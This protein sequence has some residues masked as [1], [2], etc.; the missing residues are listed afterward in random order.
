VIKIPIN[1]KEQIVTSLKVNPEL[2][3]HAKIAALEGDI[4]LG[5]LIDRAI[6]EY[7]EKQ[8]KCKK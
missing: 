5:E 8:E 3:K 1:E 4:T 7:I 2:W 6:R